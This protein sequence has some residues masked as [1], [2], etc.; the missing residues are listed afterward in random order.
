[1]ENSENLLQK[2][3]GGSSITRVTEPDVS[4]RTGSALVD[5]LFYFKPGTDGT[6]YVIIMRAARYQY[7]DSWKI[8]VTG[9]N[10]SFEQSGEDVDEY[11]HR[12]QL[13]GLVTNKTYTITMTW[14]E[15][16]TP[17]GISIKRT[18]Y[19]TNTSPSEH[20]YS[21]IYGTTTIPSYNA[22]YPNYCL[23]VKC[24]DNEGKMDGR[25][26][27]DVATRNLFWNVCASNSESH[28]V[29]GP[30]GPPHIVRWPPGPVYVSVTYKS[31][32]NQD[33]IKA[34]IN[35]WISWMNGL[36]AFAGVEFV[37]GSSTEDDARQINV[38]VG[39]H[40]Q[41]WSYN[42]D[43]VEPGVETVV[44]GG[45]WENYYW[46]E[47]IV[48]A[49]VK[50]CCEDRYPFNWGDKPFEGIVFEELIEASGPGYD[51]F[52][53]NNT[54][55]S[56]IH[57]PGKTVGGPPGEDPTRDE[58]V[59]RILYS[60]GYLKG[61]VEKASKH[62]ESYFDSG[63]TFTKSY[64][65]YGI[66][67]TTW[68]HELFFL[69]NASEGCIT[70]DSGYSIPDELSIPYKSGRDYKL[71]TVYATEV[72]DS[73]KE[74]ASGSSF[75]YTNPSAEG[76]PYFSLPSVPSFSTSSRVDGGYK[77]NVSGLN[78]DGEYYH[79]SAYIKDTTEQDIDDGSYYEFNWEKHTVSSVTVK[80]L[81]RGRAYDFY[82]HS[83][84]NGLESDWIYIGEGTVAP[85]VPVI[86]DVSRTEGSITFTYTV[87]NSEFD[88]VYCTLYRGD[89][90]VARYD[91]SLASETVTL[92]FDAD[93]GNY[94]LKVHSAI[95]VNGT[96]VA[97][98][99]NLG[100]RA[101]AEFSF[102]VADRE[103]F[104]WATYTSEMKAG[105]NIASISH[106]VW[107]KFIDVLYSVVRMKNA[108]NWNIYSA[109]EYPYGSG[110]GLAAGETYA[111]ALLNYAKMS[112]DSEAE[113]TLTAERFN[114]VNYVLSNL[115]YTGLS[116]KYSK[117]S[118]VRASEL[119]TLQDKLNLI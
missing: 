92:N 114:I 98:V 89:T 45:T 22:D 57:Y 68:E 80:T 105:G 1:M 24:P 94:V 10:Y 55:F 27:Y 43:N 39:T 79:I 83:T 103:Y 116:Y 106:T 81:A 67:D 88:T 25:C 17:H 93:N 112:G 30:M 16:D 109:N 38:I 95:W 6:A 64:R 36:V 61:E 2:R 84:Y 11:L 70:G 71:R 72:P 42:P 73:Q 52:G 8:V 3:E 54:I 14:F 87:S 21:N 62:R 63:I 37:L 118:K 4:Y 60:L 110:F 13:T 53:L 26:R 40:E 5:F 90:V 34:R 58:N 78:V 66:L 102:S 119:I 75:R 20:P 35:E 76:T 82:L 9:P 107:N 23:Q 48:E 100:G 108:E 91:S 15:G 74:T 28:P 99:N 115:I 65:N 19:C 50:I 51:Q 49:R 101:Y 85:A 56:E 41:L 111:T 32:I 29:A 7:Y 96:E 46:R 33:I 117:A 77:F 44:Y 97:C 47:G 69:I 104:Y 12:V 59:I 86:S 18:Y 31:T 113:R